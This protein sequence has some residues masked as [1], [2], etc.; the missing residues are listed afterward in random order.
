MSQLSND[1]AV[2]VKEGV[3]KAVYSDIPLNVHFAQID[4]A[5]DLSYQHWVAHDNDMK[6]RFAVLCAK[7]SVHAVAFRDPV[8][9]NAE[10]AV[11]VITLSDVYL[12]GL[13]S[14]ILFPICSGNQA[15]HYV[16]NASE[17]MVPGLP[18]NV[19]L[20]LTLK[21]QGVFVPFGEDFEKGDKNG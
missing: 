2:Y 13:D 18:S 1:V 19:V 14:A 4:H 11:A 15:R 12:Y 7:H 21:M 8:L 3:I 6:S 20:A 17:Y 9:T 10:F 5:G 16:D